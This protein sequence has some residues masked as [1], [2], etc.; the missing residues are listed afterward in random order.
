VD[1]AVTTAME[2]GAALHGSPYA[3]L[4]ASAHALAP[5]AD[6]DSDAVLAGILAG[7]LVCAFGRLEADRRLARVVDGAPEADAL[8]LEDRSRGALVLFTERSAWSTDAS[9]HTFDVSR[10]CADVAVDV[11][12]GRRIAGSAVARDL[13]GL[14]LAADAIGG[15]QRMLDRTVAY[16]SQRQTFGRLIG[17]FQA[18]QH[19]LVDHTVRARGMA[20]AVV[21]AARLLGAGSPQAR[22]FV[23]LAQVSVSSGAGPILHDLLQLTG[24]IG[25]TWEYGLHL[26]ERRAHQDARLATNP[27]AAVRSLADAEGWTNAP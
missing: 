11:T 20:L 27:R 23:A 24:A 22:R 8:L 14:L 13:Y 1:A 6:A 10:S 3:G 16:A 4:T 19:R 26:Y 18:V 17:A 21:E 5:A 12:H 7:G 25:F 15:V 2:L 9:R